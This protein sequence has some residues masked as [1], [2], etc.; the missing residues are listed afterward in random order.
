M[1]CV[2]ELFWKLKSQNHLRLAFTTQEPSK[3]P[4]AS[5]HIRNYGVLLQQIGL[6]HS[7]QSLLSGLP[8]T[9][10]VHPH[11]TVKPGSDASMAIVSLSAFKRY[12]S[13]L[14]HAVCCIF[15]I[16]FQ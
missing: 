11:G 9:Q 10:V 4:R 6:L 3:E 7:T 15:Q 2:G 13:N 12:E 5:I 1:Q 8:G 16:A 14:I